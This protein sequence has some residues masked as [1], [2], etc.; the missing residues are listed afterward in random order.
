[1]RT[2]YWG[3]VRVSGIMLLLASSSATSL[4]ASELPAL[5]VAIT[6]G[7]FVKIT[8]V[9]AEQHGQIVTEQ[10]FEGSGRDALNDVRSA[11]KSV[12]ALAVG[13]AIADQRLAG[14]DTRVM[15]AFSD[16]APFAHPSPAKEEITVEDLLTMSSAFD[17]DD[18]NDVS[19]GNEERMYESP[20]WTRF[21][22]DLPVKANYKR[23]SDGR[24]RFSYCTAGAFLLGQLIQR[25]TGERVDHYIEHQLFSPLGIDRVSWRFSP[26]GEVLTGGP[27]CRH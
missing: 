26:S 1:M 25:V 11:G 15:S 8:S 22:V 21:V 23:D 14:V 27:F 4:R 10:Y 13:L 2:L 7:D 6:H 5:T 20:N 9:V 16:L 18:W 3:L 12:T 17:C 19:P 24:G